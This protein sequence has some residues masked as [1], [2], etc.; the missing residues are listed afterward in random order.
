VDRL[1]QRLNLAQKALSSL[2][3]ALAMP[4][5]AVVRDACIQRFEHTFEAVWK[6]GQLFLKDRDGLELA[7]PKGVL[8]GCGEAGLVA[9]GTSGAG[10]ENGRQSESD[11]AF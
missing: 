4:K 3:E 9:A 6:A 8:Q 5:S 1:T 7:S 2:K 11:R 10:S